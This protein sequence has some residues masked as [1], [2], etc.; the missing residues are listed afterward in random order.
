MISDNLL[1]LL[2][3]VCSTYILLGMCSRITAF[4]RCTYLRPWLKLW[5]PKTNTMIVFLKITVDYLKICLYSFRCSALYTYTI[6]PKISELWIDL[7]QF[8][9]LFLL[10]IEEFSVRLVKFYVHS[11]RRCLRWWKLQTVVLQ[12]Y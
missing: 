1:R 4:F 10:I 7:W 6:Q 2:I 9:V 8:H 3:F 5:I 12:T 11:V